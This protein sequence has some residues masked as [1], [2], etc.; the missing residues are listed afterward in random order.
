LKKVFRDFNAQLC[1]DFARG[2]C[3]ILMTVDRLPDN[4]LRRFTNPEFGPFGFF[5]GASGFVHFR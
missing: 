1:P 4:L 5:T 3:L 2:I